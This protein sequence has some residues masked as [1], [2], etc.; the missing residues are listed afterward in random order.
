MFWNYLISLFCINYILLTYGHVIPNNNDDTI[1]EKQ[2]LQQIY[3]LNSIPKDQFITEGSTILDEGRIILTPKSNSK[4]SL[5]LKSPLSIETGSFSL[6]WTFRSFNY[7]GFSSGGLSFWLL[8]DQTIT[9]KSLFYGPA[10]FNGLQILVDNSGQFG[11]AVRGQLNDGSQTFNKDS[12]N[13]NS[14]GSCLIGYQQTSVPS[15]LRITY[16]INDDNLLKVQIDNQICFQTRKIKLMDSQSKKFSIGVTADNGQDNTESFEILKFVAYG[17]AN[18]ASKLPNIKSMPQPHLVTQMVD[19]K[20]GKTQTIDKK[21]FD[22]EK[23]NEFS[24]YDLFHKLNKLESDILVNDIRPLDQRL[25]SIIKTQEGLMKFM[26]HFV[27]TMNN[28]ESKNDDPITRDKKEFKDFLSINNKL[29]TLLEEQERIRENNKK[30]G[31]IGSNDTHV[32]DVISNLKMILIPVGFILC[33]M[34][35]FTFST[36]QYIKKQKYL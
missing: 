24:N 16:D 15:T 1:I 30:F 27:N 17:S 11:E 7:R 19:S 25:D 4:G 23:N 18:Q 6:E 12:M 28:K 3:K 14:F 29:E 21:K 26:T 35:Y 2:S 5:W 34:I 33:I 10:K 8:N 13:S 22:A 20:T 31:Q 36:Q 32:D 9:D